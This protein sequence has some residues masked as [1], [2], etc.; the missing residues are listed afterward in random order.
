[1]TTSATGT[2]RTLGQYLEALASSAPTPGG[3]SA[4]AYTGALGAALIAMVARLT[5]PVDDA[6]QA[7][8]DI[9]ASKAD[10]VQV[11]LTDCA[12]ADE[13]V[14]AAYR[15]ATARPKSTDD[16][17]ASRTQAMQ[18]ALVRAAEAPIATASAAAT[19][20]N[21]AA[22]CAAIGTRHALSDIR[23]ARHL[24]HA[25]INGAFENVQVNLDM[26]KDATE[27]DRLISAVQQIQ[28]S[29]GDADLALDQALRS[30]VA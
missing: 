29:V 11:S 26:I 18:A 30:R 6:A 2:D 23:T 25:A 8:L 3:G 5:K 21:L 19:A 7:A 12:I 4:S 28:A 1:M 16:E 15:A 10:E 20:L 13:A 9:I 27:R 24:L 22:K 17:K 14:Y